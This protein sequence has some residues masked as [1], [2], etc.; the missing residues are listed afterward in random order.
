MTDSEI[1]TTRLRWLSTGPVEASPAAVKAEVAKL[2]FL[3]SMDAD[4]LDLSVLPA[5]R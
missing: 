5:E 3:R 2:E 4:S 1:R